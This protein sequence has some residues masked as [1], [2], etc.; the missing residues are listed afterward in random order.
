MH[1][2]ITYHGVTHSA[3]QQENT[4]LETNGMHD[5]TKTKN[6]VIAKYSHCTQ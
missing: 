6:I 4:S 3:T 5:T 1:G 2:K